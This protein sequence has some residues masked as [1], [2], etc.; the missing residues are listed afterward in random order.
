M[1]SVR[2]CVCVFQLEGSGI[3]RY[4]IEMKPK[5]LSHVIAM[6]ALFRPGPMKF[7]PTHIRRMH[8]EEDVSYLHPA[9]EPIFSETYGIP[10][11]QEQIM[12]AAMDLAGYSVADAD[13]LRMAIS[14]KEAGG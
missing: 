5:E 8:G 12:F 3:R 14:K 2:E 7:I 6:V 9:L 13:H 4:L 11:Y 10:V 1:S